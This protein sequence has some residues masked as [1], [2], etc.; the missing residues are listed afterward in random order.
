MLMID[1]LSVIRKLF[2]HTQFCFFFWNLCHSL[3]PPWTTSNVYRQWTVTV[4][5]RTC[6][7][8]EIVLWTLI[9]VRHSNLHP[10]ACFLLLYHSCVVNYLKILLFVLFNSVGDESEWNKIGLI[11][12]VVSILRVSL[13]VI[14]SPFLA[15]FIISHWFHIAYLS[16]H[17]NWSK[18]Y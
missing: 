2:I 5:H 13:H 16:L 9:K 15:L 7:F 4:F 12:L 18:I 1:G 3:S 10:L 14:S 6:T 11:G 8:R 17:N